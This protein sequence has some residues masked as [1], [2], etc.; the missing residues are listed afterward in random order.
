MNQTQIPHNLM[1]NPLPPRGRAQELDGVIGPLL[2]EHCANGAEGC[3]DFI[4][5]CEA[6]WRGVLDG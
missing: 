5:D 4:A 2:R 3:A 1:F 6:R